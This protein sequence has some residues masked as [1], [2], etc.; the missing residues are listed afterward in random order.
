MSNKTK[1]SLITLPVELV[2]RILDKL[3][4]FTILCSM[5]NVCTRINA[6]VNTYHRYQVNIFLQYSFISII[7]K[8]LFTPTIYIISLYYY[9]L[10]LAKE[11]VII[12]PNIRKFLIVTNWWWKLCLLPQKFFS[13]DGTIDLLLSETLAI[14]L[15][16]I[17][18]VSER[19]EDGLSFH[20]FIS[21]SKFLT[22]IDC[23]FRE[24]RS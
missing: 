3:D 18:I 15:R 7:W 11:Y 24:G 19:A 14:F 4:N 10:L 9:T 22:K 2:Y 21:I 1:P 12:F 23:F 17:N 6:I 5:L 20:A 13:Y 8:I 16:K